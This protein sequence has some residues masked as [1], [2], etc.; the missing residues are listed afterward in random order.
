MKRADL[1]WLLLMLLTGVG[2]WLKTEFST[3][4]ALGFAVALVIAVKGRLVIDFY[5]ELPGAN[6]WLR[7]VMHAYF[8]LLPL[9]VVISTLWGDAIRRL[10]TI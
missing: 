7:R 9:L 4:F 1:T 2:V 8:Y 6:A 5:M 3:G 10:T